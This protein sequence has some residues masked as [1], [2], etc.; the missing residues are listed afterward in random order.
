MLRPAVTRKAFHSSLKRLSPIKTEEYTLPALIVGNRLISK[1][2]RNPPKRPISQNPKPRKKQKENPKKK[3]SKPNE[4]VFNFKGGNDAVLEAEVREMLGQDPT[5]HARRNGR[6]WSTEAN[7]GRSLD[8]LHDL[9]EQFTEVEVTITRLSSAGDGLGH[10]SPPPRENHR[11][12]D[13]IYVVPFTLPGDTALAKVTRHNYDPDYTVTDYVRTLAPSPTR[14]DS[15]VR[16]PY[17]T[18]CS[19]CQLQQAPYAYQLAHKRRVIQR[20][21]AYFSHLPA[22]AVPEVGE[23]VPSPLR[24]AYRTKLTPHFDGP[25]GGRRA[26]RR[27]E[28]PRFESVPP[29]GFIAKGTRRTLDIEECPIGTPAVNKGLTRER[30]AVV[31]SLGGFR[32]GKTILL[33]ESTRRVSREEAEQEREDDLTAVVEGGEGGG[34]TEVK[35]CV[36]DNNAYTT[37]YVGGY[38]FRNQANAFFQ[39]NNSILPAFTN[40]IRDNVVEPARDDITDENVNLNADNNSPRIKNLID[41]YCGS[42]LFTITLSP[43]FTRS[44]GVDISEQSISSA[45]E[46]L[47]LN[48]L[49]QTSHP[50]HPSPEQQTTQNIT[51]KKATASTIF[52]PSSSNQSLNPS[53]TVVIIDPPR[54]GCDEA[55]LSQLLR[56]GPARCVYVSCNVHTQARDV[57]WILRGGSDGEREPTPRVEGPLG[58]YV[59]GEEEDGEEP[60]RLDENVNVNVKEEDEGGVEPPRVDANANVKVKEEEDKQPPGLYAEKS[61]PRTDIKEE[62][63]KEVKEE[64]D[65]G[66]E[67]AGG[68]EEHSSG[69]Y[70]IESIR[71][72]D[73][74][75]QT[76]H[77]ESVCVLRRKRTRPRGGAAAAMAG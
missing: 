52:P 49:N 31:E 19:G 38:V 77:V 36:S 67:T 35:S 66:G 70:E 24:Y 33:R 72:F 28:T 14:D 8:R 27:G 75:P 50:P 41:A 16:C 10:R 7:D 34:I 23:T 22:S 58:W 1:M 21:Y 47:A 11:D 32:K 29:I 4:S 43:L 6:E 45:L 48:N 57:G 71:P 62:D 46:N 5:L 15:L 65:D 9:P 26:A 44:I 39:N 30:R 25:Q 56:F 69:D 53:E 61:P 73:F 74:F 55:F 59:K 54:K 12:R 20:A 68:E 42:G 51:F 60:P 76:G 64:D 13:R 63:V 37:E 3:S 2:P 17:F 18:R 40:Y